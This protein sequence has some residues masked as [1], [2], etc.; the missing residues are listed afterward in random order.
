MQFKSF[1]AECSNGTIRHFTGTCF[2]Q[3]K[4][5][6]GG[7]ISIISHTLLLVPFHQKRARLELNLSFLCRWGKSL[8]AAKSGQIL[9]R[10][11]F[12]DEYG[13]N[14]KICGN[15]ANIDVNLDMVYIAD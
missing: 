8:S 10:K 7:P 2:T 12:Y 3:E 11:M 13:M 4:S 14:S 1:A 15:S 6:T 9:F 5:A